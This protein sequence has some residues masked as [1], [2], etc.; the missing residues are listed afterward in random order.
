MDFGAQNLCSTK[1]RLFV[2]CVK[3]TFV[4]SSTVA[5][6]VLLRAAIGSWVYDLCVVGHTVKTQSIHTLSSGHVTRSTTIWRSLPLCGRLAVLRA[7]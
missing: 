1:H 4:S 3:S 5:S 6:S 2:V 7:S